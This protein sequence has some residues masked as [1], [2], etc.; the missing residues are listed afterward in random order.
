MLPLFCPGCRGWHAELLPDRAGN[1]RGCPRCG[2]LERH[3]LLALLLPA[4]AAG[5]AAPQDPAPQDPAPTATGRESA[6]VVDVAPSVALEPALARLPHTRQIRMDF[7]PAADGRQVDV[8]A[9][10]TAIPLPDR[11]VDLLICSHVLEHVPDDGLAMRELCRVLTDT[12]LGIVI[13]PQHEGVP[14]DEDPDAGPEERIARFGQA[15]HVRYYG[16]DVSDRLAAAG[17]AVSSFRCDEVVEPWLVRLLHLMPQERFWLVRA[18]RAGREE[19]PRADQLRENLSQV[20]EDAAEQAFATSEALH[21]AEQETARWREVAGKWRG[22]YQ[23][24]HDHPAVR[25]MLSVRRAALRTRG[26]L[27]PARGGS[28]G[29]PA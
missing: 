18:G 23:A 14:T 26:R 25:I 4:L 7:D 17:L 8:Q 27:T 9:S 13:V 5:A 22:H 6:L 21:R 1:P 3:R 11:S 20:L 29:T 24:L 15:D 28:R 2:S 19:L 10:V 12:G 16:D